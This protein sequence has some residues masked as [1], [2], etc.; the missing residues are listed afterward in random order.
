LADTM[1]NS[2]RAAPPN[3][4]TGTVGR[5]ADS[6]VAPF[7]SLNFCFRHANYYSYLHAVGINLF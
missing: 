4:S 3:V 7:V 5:L 2:G 6:S 1:D